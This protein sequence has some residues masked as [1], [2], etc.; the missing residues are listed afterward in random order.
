VDGDDGHPF[1]VANE[2]NQ[3]RRDRPEE[4]R[5]GPELGSRPPDGMIDQQIEGGLEVPVDA[6]RDC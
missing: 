4:K 6:I 2:G 1:S 5:L 3:R